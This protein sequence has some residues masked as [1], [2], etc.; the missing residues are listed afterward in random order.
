MDEW[1]EIFPQMFI[2]FKICL[3][4]KRKIIFTN[5]DKGRGNNL[6][7]VRASSLPTPTD[8]KMKMVRRFIA[9]PA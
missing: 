2:H 1:E 4:F 6:S 3:L 9:S 5:P 8:Y 7:A